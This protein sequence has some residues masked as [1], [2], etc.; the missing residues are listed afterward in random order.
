MLKALRVEP[1]KCTGCLQC[2]LACSFEH[3]SAYNPSRSRIKVFAFHD[4]AR[5][6]LGNVTAVGGY[7]FVTD[8]GNNPLTGTVTLS[9][10]DGTS[11][12]VA[13]GSPVPFLGYTADLPLSSLTISGPGNNHWVSM[14]DFYVGSADSPDVPEPST[15]MLGG[16]GLLALASLRRLHRN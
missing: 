12:T 10:N 5:F 3:E 11:T 15:W 4:T 8:V 14:D 7:F 9:F 13:S 2:E 1:R 6:I 16:A